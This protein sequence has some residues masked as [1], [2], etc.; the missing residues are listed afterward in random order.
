MPAAHDNSRSAA[1]GLSDEDADGYRP[2]HHRTI[3]PHAGE[4]LEDSRNWPGLILAGLGI[5]AVALTLTAAGYGFEGWAFIGGVV[6]VLLL[7][8][9]ITQ[10]VLEH[11]RIERLD[12]EEQ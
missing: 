5:V 4:A 7:G 11:R 12:Q 2:D 8:S 6:S 9:G 3:R 10:V 1:L